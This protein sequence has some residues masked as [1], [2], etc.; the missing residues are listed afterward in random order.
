MAS[1]LC[2]TSSA[3]RSSTSSQHLRSSAIRCRWSD[4]VQHSVNWSARPLCQHSNFRTVVKNTPFLCLSARLA[5][6][7]VSCNALY[8][9]KSTL[10]TYFTWVTLT[11]KVSYRVL[12]TILSWNL[13]SLHF[14]SF[15]AVHSPVWEGHGGMVLNRM[16]GEEESRRHQLAQV[17]L[18]RWSEWECRHIGQKAQERNCQKP[19]VQWQLKKMHEYDKFYFTTHS[20]VWKLNHAHQQYATALE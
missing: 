14:S 7:G 15:I 1:T 4:D 16:C 13:L 10:L 6:W 8:K 2:Y 9:Y 19:A 3:D 20:S 12:V 18:D 5:H 17:H 11:R